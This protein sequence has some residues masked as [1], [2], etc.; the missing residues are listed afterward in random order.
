MAA[1]IPRQPVDRDRIT[2]PIGQVYIIPERCKSCLFC[3]EFCPKDVLEKS[4]M[5]NS[6]GYEYPRVAA[7]KEHACVNCRFCMLVC[8]EFA[9]YTEA[10]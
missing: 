10:R 9:V 3:V 2:V 8:P 1:A 7:G 5:M 6:K 4:P